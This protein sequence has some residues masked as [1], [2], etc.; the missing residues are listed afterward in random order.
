M[1]IFCDQVNLENKTLTDT[2]LG[3]YIHF[4]LSCMTFSLVMS[5]FCTL[6]YGSPT[7]VRVN[8]V[9]GKTSLECVFSCV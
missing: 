8:H 6:E 1:R 4:L 2:V 9:F 5:L 3:I 7:P